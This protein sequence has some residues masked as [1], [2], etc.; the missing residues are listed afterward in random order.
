MDDRQR[1]RQ[2]HRLDEG[3]RTCVK[4][5]LHESRTHAVPGEGPVPADVFIIGEAPGGT[6]DRKGR[7]FVGPSGVV[8]KKLL[9]VAGLT[10]EDVYITSCVKCRPP[11]N[12]PPRT[13]ELGTCQANWLDRQI[14]LVN[15]KLVVLLGK[16]AIHQL[17]H[18]E[19]S[20]VK[21]H[22]ETV[23]RD[24]RLFLMTYHPAAV[25]RVP[26]IEDSMRED[27]ARLRQLAGVGA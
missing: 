22:G 17:L 4:C 23:E 9:A 15:P 8:L 13:D 14:D 27:M 5:A 1:Q 21:L 18:E 6:E 26:Q 10:R 24:G 2:M 19:G 25:F 11:A 12:R 16:V 7:P 3:I 20:L